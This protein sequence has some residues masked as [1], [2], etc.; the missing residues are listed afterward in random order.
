LCL[1]EGATM[2]LTVDGSPSRVIT[3]DRFESFSGDVNT[4][5]HLPHGK[6]V[7]LGLIIDRRDL[8]PILHPRLLTASCD[9]TFDIDASCKVVVIVHSIKG[10]WKVNLNICDDVECKEVECESGELC[11]AHLE[12]SKDASTGRLRCSNKCSDDNVASRLM[13]SVFQRLQ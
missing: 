6:V 8:L 2:Q 10:D 3:N 1:I 13:I 4:V 5:A 11:F 9:V 7:D 12:V